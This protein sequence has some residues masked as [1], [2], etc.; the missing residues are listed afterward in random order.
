MLHQF[1]FTLIKQYPYSLE[2]VTIGVLHYV[3]HFKS[4]HFKYV[5]PKKGFETYGR[6]NFMWAIFFWVRKMSDI[7]NVPFDFS[8]QQDVVE[9]L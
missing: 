9:V 8:S 5:H 6:I 7:C 4:Y 2:Q 3:S 1:N